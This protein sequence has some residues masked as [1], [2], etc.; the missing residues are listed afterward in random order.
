[1]KGFDIMDLSFFLSTEFLMA[2]G[3]ILII[4]LVLAGDNAIVIGM[5]ARNVPVDRQKQVILLGTAG[6]IGTRIVATVGVVHLL[7][8]PGLLFVGGVA[9]LYISYKLL[10][11]ESSHEIAPKSQ[12]W[13][14]VRTIVIADAVMGLDNVLAVAGASNGSTLLVVLGIAITVPLVIWGSTFF[15]KAVDKFPMVLTVGAIV[16]ILTAADMITKEPFLKEYLTLTSL[17][18]WGLALLFSGGILGFSHYLKAEQAPSS[19]Y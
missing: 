14:A 18:K 2:L 10:T 8:L 6:A 16:I 4:D 13:L 9:L 5:A 11:D 17:H 12:F 1:M 15:I 3:A 7:N 19:D